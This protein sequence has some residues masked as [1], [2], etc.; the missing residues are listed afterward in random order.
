[1]SAVQHPSPRAL[2]A[3]ALLLLP[4]AAHGCSRGYPLASGGQ[5]DIRVDVA[6][7]LFATD[8]LDPS[9]KPA[10]PRQTPHQTGVSLFL[11]EGGAA[12]FGA[13]VS[14]R[15]EPREALVLL[16]ASDENTAEPTCEAVDGSFRCF[17]SPEGFAR[18][19]ASSESDWSGDATLI[20]SWAD[21]TEE[22]II[23]VLPAGLPDKATN[24]TMVVGLDDND[25]VLATFSG[26]ACSDDA[27][28]ED[29]GSKWRDGAIR[30]REARV[31]ATPPVSAPAVVENAPVIVESLYSEAAL[32][33]D[34]KCDDRQTR[35]RLLLDATG[36]SPRFYLCFSDIGGE[37]SFAISSGQKIVE[38]SPEV[39]VEPEPR[40]LRVSP[41]QTIVE[42]GTQVDLFEVSAFNVNRVRIPMPVDLR[43]DDE[44]V[45][46]LAQASLTLAGEGNPATL[47]EVD[48]TAS[49]T[50][51][52]HV[53]PR[54]LS[55]P[56]CA[57]VPITVVETP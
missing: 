35:L 54:L 43:S 56:D 9:G 8:T 47:V 39:V 28:P 17:A 44:Q 3:A 45:L 19:V 24:F 30:F 5:V 29:L 42:L 11:T 57:S 32:S 50:T 4:L 48:P 38:P 6:G 23:P 21:R 53:T 52:I 25:T 20:V 12:A 22:K 1:M 10:G 55:K 18:F 26:L 49:G 36:E 37:A 2:A 27:I 34:E 13:F 16:A 51:Q 15:V 46:K 7:A 40:L 33:L 31:R 14:V 41:V